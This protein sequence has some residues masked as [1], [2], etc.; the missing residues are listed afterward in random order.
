MIGGASSHLLAILPSETSSAL[1]NVAPVGVKAGAV[2]QA[3]L[4]QAFVAV[5]LTPFTLISANY[6]R[7]VSWL[8]IS[9]ICLV[10]FI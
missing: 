1:A 5:F 7:I 4:V 9:S 3:W 8:K 10:F 6:K 2:I